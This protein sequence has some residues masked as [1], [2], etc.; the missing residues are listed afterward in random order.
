MVRCCDDDNGN[1]D[2][3]EDDNADDFVWWREIVESLCWWCGVRERSCDEAGEKRALSCWNTF[4]AANDSEQRWNDPLP[5][6]THD[7]RNND[8]S[9]ITT[10]PRCRKEEEEEKDGAG[11]GTGWRR[12]FMEIVVLCSRCTKMNGRA[13]SKIGC[14]K[15]GR[16]AKKKLDRS[17]ATL[18]CC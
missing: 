15:D 16:R 17:K 10:F 14:G 18:R 4:L 3:D 2:D 1:D 9:I 13:F 7:A 12:W 11:V 8:D 5:T 6:T